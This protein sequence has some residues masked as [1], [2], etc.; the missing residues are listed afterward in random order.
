MAARYLNAEEKLVM[1]PVS[2]YRK[3]NAG[4]KRKIRKEEKRREQIMKLAME[5]E[6]LAAKL[7][8]LESDRG[9]IGNYVT[10]N[11]PGPTR[12]GG[13]VRPMGALVGPHRHSP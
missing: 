5:K 12:E 4:L 1:I 10:R 6:Q 9:F 2:N 3:I 8:E 11:E 13:F 7:R